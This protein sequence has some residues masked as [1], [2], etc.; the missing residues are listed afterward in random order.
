MESVGTT[1]KKFIIN[2]TFQFGN[3]S[4][5]A[6]YQLDRCTYH[7]DNTS[8]TLPDYTIYTLVSLKLYF[9]IFLGIQFIQTFS[10]FILKT[11]M[12][13]PFQQLN[14]LE[15]VIHCLE[16]TNLPYNVQEWD[17]PREGQAEDHVKRMK[18]NRIE[19][20]ALITLNFIFKLVMLIP[21]FL[22]GN[23]IL[24]R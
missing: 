9:L 10:I 16:S 22:L 15:K 24:N 11:K 1:S 17:T 13:T 19:G 3:S 2:G 21:I 8:P 5:I 4:P 7:L 12:A 23:N 20:L 14:I 6:W 18:A